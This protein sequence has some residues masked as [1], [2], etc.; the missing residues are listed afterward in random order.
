MSCSSPDPCL[1]RTCSTCEQVRRAGS[2]VPQTLWI[3]ICILTRPAGV[4]CARFFET[5]WPRCYLSDDIK[6]RTRIMRCNT[7][8]SNHMYRLFG[9]VPHLFKGTGK[10]MV[11]R[12]HKPPSAIGHFKKGE[13]R[14][15]CIAPSPG[16]SRANKTALLPAKRRGASLSRAISGGSRSTALSFSV[17]MP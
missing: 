11:P 15:Q 13:K 4:L 2:Q 9:Q 14:S 12:S 7:V 8:L 1:W 6:T 16:A 3:Q 10:R 17:T 5:H